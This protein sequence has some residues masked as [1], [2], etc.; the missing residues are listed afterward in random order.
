MNKYLEKIA[1]LSEDR[2]SDLTNTA[3]LGA[4]G[5]AETTGMAKLLNHTRLRGLSG[6]AKF[7]IGA[8][9]T[10]AADYAGLKIGKTLNKWRGGTPQPTKE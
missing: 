7:G 5:G 4:I 1:A 8:G 6:T 2:K 3:V 10:L 9:A